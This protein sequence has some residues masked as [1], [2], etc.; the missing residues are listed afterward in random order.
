M[1]ALIRTFVL[2]VFAAFILTAFLLLLVGMGV[3]G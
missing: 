2:G 3:L 1:P